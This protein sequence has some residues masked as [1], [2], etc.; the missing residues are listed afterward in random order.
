MPTHDICFTNDNKWFRLRACAII[1]END[2]VLMAGNEGVGFL[3]SIGGGVHHGETAEE[4]IV[5]EVFEETGVTYEIDRLAFI[6]ENLFV[7]QEGTLEGR[8]CHE[9]A[10]YFLMKSRGTQ[11]TYCDSKTA[12][13]KEFVKWIPICEFANHTAY[14]AFFA[15]KLINM[16]RSVEHIVTCET[17]QRV[18]E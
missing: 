8:E 1:I 6:H 16:P 14:P 18:C 13:G 2:C 4:A 5:R 15:E 10:F 3:Y 17:E 9:V 11:E 7:M 12:D